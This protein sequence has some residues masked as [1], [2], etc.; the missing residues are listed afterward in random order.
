MNR[1]KLLTHG[2]LK[3]AVDCGLPV[4]A[5]PSLVALA[6]YSLSMTP[7]RTEKMQNQAA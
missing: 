2:E 3:E 1:L 6:T 5:V 4:W 7:S